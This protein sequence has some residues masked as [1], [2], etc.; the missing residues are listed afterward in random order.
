MENLAASPLWNCSYAAVAGSNRPA[1]VADHFGSGLDSAQFDGTD[2]TLFMY[3]AA[4]GSLS[5]FGT[6]ANYPL[7]IVMVIDPTSITDAVLIGNGSSSAGFFDSYFSGMALRSEG[8]MRL[9]TRDNSVGGAQEG[10]TSVTAAGGA[11]TFSGVLA[12]GA[13]KGRINGTQVISPAAFTINPYAYAFDTIS[14]TAGAGGN[15]RNPF[16]GHIG[17]ILVYSGALGDAALAAAEAF[18]LETP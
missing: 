5:I 2:D 1:H 10:G 12:A 4:N 9:A 6:D 15:P 3:S 7:T 18:V 11:Y 13:P 17:R 16:A 14:G 8:G